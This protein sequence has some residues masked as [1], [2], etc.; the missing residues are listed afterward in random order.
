MRN[1]QA[2]SRFEN[3]SRWID[4]G[5]AN[6]IAREMILLSQEEIA[7]WLRSETNQFKDL[8]YSGDGETKIGEGY[9]RGNPKLKDRYNATI[10]LKKDGFGGY[11]VITAFPR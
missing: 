3:A 7:E 2:R 6:R 4:E 11:R 9:D 10:R 8:D 1:L 5:V